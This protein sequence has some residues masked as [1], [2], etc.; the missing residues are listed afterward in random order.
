MLLLLHG[1]KCRIIYHFP[2]NRLPDRIFG[3]FESSKS[4]RWVNFIQLRNVDRRIAKHLVGNSTC[5]GLQSISVADPTELF[6]FF[7]AKETGVSLRSQISRLPEQPCW[8]FTLIALQLH[9]LLPRRFY[10]T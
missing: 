6:T 8:L 9:S 4:T 5:F 2:P 7:G 10:P 1:C 3:C